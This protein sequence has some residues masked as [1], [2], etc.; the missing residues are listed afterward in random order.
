V[1][2]RP[3]TH[4]D[5]PGILAIY[6]EVVANSTAIWAFDPA[7][8]AERIDWFEARARKGYPV[9][10]AEG[11]DGIEGFA[12]YGEFRSAPGY[13]QTVEHTVHVRSG[14]RRSG[15]GSALVRELLSRA[16]AQGMHVCLG[17]IAADNEASLR[18]HEKLG[19]ERTAHLREVGR[20]F[21]RW[22]DLVIVQIAL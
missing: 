19:F 2:V 12:S 16:R 1:I 10:V 5:L 14:C 3:A 11:E 8:L 20:K 9:L 18:M 4:S 7:T 17:G 15:V 21:D 22:L 13:A 6:N